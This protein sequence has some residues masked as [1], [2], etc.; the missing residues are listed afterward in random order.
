MSNSNSA[1]NQA[2][3]SD[4]LSVKQ[5][6]DK[7]LEAQVQNLDFTVTSKLAAARHRAMD[8]PAGRSRWQQLFGWQSV[9]GSA[10]VLTVAYVIG[11]NLL[12]TP[13]LVPDVPANGLATGDLMEDLTILAEGDDI[14]FYQNIEFLEWL[15]SNS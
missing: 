3:T 4:E 12:T 5:A 1:D 15:E 14:E 11:G 8:Q 9:A 6:L 13:A 2:L 7:H 10:A